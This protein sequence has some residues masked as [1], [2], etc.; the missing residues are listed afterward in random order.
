MAFDAAFTRAIVNEISHRI[1]SGARV[2]KLFQPTRDS[3]LFVL[4]CEGRDG[5]KAV[6]RKLLIDGGPTSPRI[7]FTD[8]EVE[9]PKVPPMFCMLLRKHLGSSRLIKIE[10]MGFERVIKLTFEC[11][12]ELGYLSNKYIFAEL[13]GK[14]SNLLFCDSDE[15]IIS[16][17]HLN[18]LSVSVKRPVIVGVKY[19]LPPAQ[20]G[21]ISPFS[22]TKQSFLSDL[23]ESRLT[24][25]KFIQNRYYG[26]SPLVARELAYSAAGSDESLWY[27]LC[28]LI[29]LLESEEYSP[30]I[31]KD[32]NG[33]QIE[34]SFMPIRQYEGGALC[35][36]KESFSS[37]IDEFF[38]DRSKTERIKQRAS[39]ILKLIT[40]AQTRLNNRL[41]KQNEELEACSDKESLKRM[42]DLITANIYMLKRGMTEARVVDYYDENCPTVTLTLDSRLT[43]AQNAQRYY[44]RY[45]KSKSAE[46][47]LFEQIEQGERELVYLDTVFDSL[48][49]AETEADLNEIRRELYL[50]GYASKMKN[51]V[52]AKPTAPKPLEYRTSGGWRVLCGKNNSQNE[53]I[54]HKVATKSDLWFH[55]KDYP[56]SH[57]VLICN[58]EEPDAVDYTEAANI[59]AVNSK[60]PAGQRVTVDYTR[61]KNLK[62]PPNA[63]PGFVTFS[64]NFSAYVIPEPEKAEA[65]KVK[66]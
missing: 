33:S 1:G 57:T 41:I 5:E 9:N 61:I 44:K 50:S 14:F 16:A 30:V 52:Q 27:A 35:E 3:I 58:G 26:L 46:I 38:L 32:E 8:T 40:N 37:L 21:K 25:V 2:E 36:V 63:K 48:T 43:P 39:D 17:F 59:A 4:R 10:Q 34:Y 6:T 56:G 62:K 13:M 18:D 55:V 64:N 45:N 47:H 19:E 7:C 53:Y 42:G 65:L 51:Y 29:L 54:T 20:E 31:V 24:H 11:R 28:G 22:D 60:A 23:S 15:R 12:D 66:K 49:R